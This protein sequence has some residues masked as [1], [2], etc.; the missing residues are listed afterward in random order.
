MKA[1]IQELQQQA[2][3]EKEDA[4]VVEQE[5]KLPEGGSGADT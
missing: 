3:G 4:P 5:E 2:E 1:K